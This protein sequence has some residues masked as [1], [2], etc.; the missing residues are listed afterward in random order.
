MKTIVLERPGA[1][2]LHDA[3]EPTLLQPDEALVRVHRVGI[4]GTDLHAYEGTQP[5]FSY[6]RVLGHELPP[7]AE[8][9]A[10][11]GS[12][13][14]VIATDAPLDAR[15]LQRLATRAFAGMAR[16]GASF[17]NGSGDY[18]IAFSTAR[19]RPLLA[20]DAMSGLFVAVADAT[21]QAILDSL[22]RATTVRGCGR[23]S[24][25]VPI[26]AVRRAARGEG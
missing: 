20:N 1:F 22:L 19:N 8:P 21:E 9:P 4:C 14:I 16:I 13:M 11:R 17:S 10:D 18:A 3:P 5:F 26:D 25:A 24:R 2:A 15:N 6:P 7:V 12:C 23:E